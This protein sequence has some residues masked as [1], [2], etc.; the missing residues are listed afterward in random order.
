MT[1]HANVLQLPLFGRYFNEKV[2]CMHHV[3]RRVVRVRR[4]G[5]EPIERRR[6]GGNPVSNYNAPQFDPR[7][8]E[9]RVDPGVENGT[10]RNV[11]P[12]F[13][14]D[15]YAQYRFILHRLVIIHAAD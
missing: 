11:D 14:C 4:S 8:A 3:V 15:F 1:S 5:V 2:V 13:L 6:L 10:N 12:I 9:G 7:L